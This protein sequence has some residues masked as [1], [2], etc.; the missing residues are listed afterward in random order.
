MDKK[1]A[2]GKVNKTAKAGKP[3]K[4]VAPTKT[5]K[6]PGETKQKKYEDIH[7]VDSTKPV[8]NYSIFTGEDIKNFQQGTH[9]NLYK[10]F[11][12]RPARVLDTDGYYFA[13]WAPNATFISV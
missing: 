1:S 6:M 13:V 3:V 8:W 10:L 2:T 11:G 7:F 12:S 9:Y 4:E 5:K